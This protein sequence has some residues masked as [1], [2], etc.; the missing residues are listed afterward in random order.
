MTVQYW[1]YVEDYVVHEPQWRKVRTFCSYEDAEG[2]IKN[3]L[4]NYQDSYHI[5]KVYTK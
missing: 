4:E 2:F 3:R 5:K 1:V